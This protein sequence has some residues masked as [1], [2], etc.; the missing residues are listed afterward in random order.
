MPAKVNKEKCIGCEQCIPVCPTEAIIMHKEIA[1][2]D[3]AECIHCE[4]CIDECAS[5][6]ISMK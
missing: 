6:A 2:I 1:K 4:T 5:D 3:P